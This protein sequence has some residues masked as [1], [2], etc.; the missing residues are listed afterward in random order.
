MA[1][2]RIIVI[3]GMAAVSDAVFDQSGRPTEG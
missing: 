2:E 3:G 1:P